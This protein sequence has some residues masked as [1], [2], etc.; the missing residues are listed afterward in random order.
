MAPWVAGTTEAQ[1]VPVLPT[2]SMAAM[3]EDIQPTELVVFW[4]I[5][6]VAFFNHQKDNNMG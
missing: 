1:E 6:M 5:K 2:L 3:V 4:W